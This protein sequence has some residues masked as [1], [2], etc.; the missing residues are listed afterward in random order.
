MCGVVWRDEMVGGCGRHCHSRPAAA[1]QPGA[2][3]CDHVTRSQP[4]TGP[5]ITVSGVTAPAESEIPTCKLNFIP[6]AKMFSQ[7]F[8][9]SCLDIF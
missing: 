2:Q 6:P 4:I 1:D 7:T 9:Q 5:D 3:D 8:K